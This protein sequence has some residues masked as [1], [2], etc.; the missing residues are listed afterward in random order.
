MAKKRIFKISDW[1]ASPFRLQFLEMEKPRKK[2][3][4]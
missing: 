1:T 4:R 3:V 2:K